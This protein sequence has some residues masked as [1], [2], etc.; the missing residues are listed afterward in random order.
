M[1]LSGVHLSFMSEF[2]NSKDLMRLSNKDIIDNQSF[3]LSRKNNFE[4]YSAGTDEMYKS[5]TNELKKCCILHSFKKNYELLKILH[6]GNES[7]VYEA[8]SL[9]NNIISIVKI[10]DKTTLIKNIAQFQGVSKNKFA[11]AI[12]NEINLLKRLLNHDN[13]LQ[14]NEVYETKK[15]IVLIFDKL[16]GGDL[17]TNKIPSSFHNKFNEN[18]IKT[19][20]KQLLLAVKFLHDN[21]IMHR[22]I[23]KKN[24]FFVNPNDLQLKLGDFGLAEYASKQKFVFRRCGTPGYVA[25]EILL[26]QPY[27]KKCD[28][29]SLGSLLYNL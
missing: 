5:W 16:K 11:A 25:P 3:V 14:L 22:D 6:P 7:T 8:N 26:K 12:E 20:M 17:D 10:F 4:I 23:K 13:I 15:K 24:V 27:N 9:K 1:L 21:D 29:F 18:N 28:L 19:I 2:F